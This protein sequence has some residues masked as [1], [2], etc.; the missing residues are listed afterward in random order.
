MVQ[1]S[2]QDTRVLKYNKIASLCEFQ[3]HVLLCLGE[4]TWSAIFLLIFTRLQHPSLVQDYSERETGSVF[5]STCNIPLNILSLWPRNKSTFSLPFMHDPTSNIPKEQ[6]CQPSSAHVDSMLWPPAGVQLNLSSTQGK[7]GQNPTIH[8]NSRALRLKSEVLLW[9]TVL[10]PCNPL[11]PKFCSF[12]S[13]PH[14]QNRGFTEGIRPLHLPSVPKGICCRQQSPLGPVS[15]TFARICKH[16]FHA[17]SSQVTDQTPSLVKRLSHA[18]KYIYIYTSIWK[19]LG[20]VSR[21]SAAEAEA[22]VYNLSTQFV[23]KVN[24]LPM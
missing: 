16:S 2:L 7:W 6:D 23:T 13:G 17:G 4:E 18:C 24:R 19:P 15:S 3:I 21:K 8:T 11:G 9:Y 12:G 22:W 5:Q 14:D 20:N 1:W 10:G